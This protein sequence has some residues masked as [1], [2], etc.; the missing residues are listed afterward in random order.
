MSNQPSHQPT[1]CLTFDFDAISAWLGTLG[2]SS[3]VYVSRSDFAANVA[4]PRI[5]D[6][7]A[8]EGITATWFIPGMDADT[9]P[10]VCKRIRDAGHEIGHHGYAHEVPT[11]L[12]EPAERKMIERGLESLDKVLGVRPQG[13]RSPAADLS[14]NSN[15]LL[16][17]YGFTYDSSMMG[18]D[19]ELYR[20]RAGD[21]VHPDKALEFGQEIDLVEV[22][23]GS[24]GDLVFMEFVMA[25]PLVLPGNADFEGLGRRWVTDL[26]YMAEEVPHG[27]FTPVFHPVAIGRGGRIRLMERLIQRAREHN[28]RFVTVSQAVADWKAATASPS[29]DPGAT[30]HA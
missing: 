26:D 8:R 24:V 20:C 23:I 4:T 21:V 11:S 13:F 25:P 9:Y 17:E 16:A 5:L 7:L 27:V 14:F 12:D 29:V 22:P 3:P 28:A 10:D 6:L 18:H 15:R 2:L 30:A 19:F 1:F